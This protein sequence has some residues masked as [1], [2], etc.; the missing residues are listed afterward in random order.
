M[1]FRLGCVVRRCRIGLD[2]RG[3][4]RFGFS[5]R[6]LRAV[7]GYTP[8]EQ[9][10]QQSGLLVTRGLESTKFAGVSAAFSTFMTLGEKQQ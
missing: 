7:S 2:R 4:D 1:R 10:L 6:S 8:F 9:M 5:R 3:P